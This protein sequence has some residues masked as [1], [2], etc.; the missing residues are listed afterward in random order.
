MSWQMDS[1]L[2]V[3]FA[4]ILIFVAS[5]VGVPVPPSTQKPFPEETLDFLV[6]GDTSREDVDAYF[7]KAPAGFRRMTFEADTVRTYAATAETWGVFWCA[8]SP[9][10][11]G[12]GYLFPRREVEHYLTLRFSGN[13]AL[14]HFAVSEFGCDREAGFCATYDGRETMALDVKGHLPVPSFATSRDEACAFYV[15]TDGPF[16]TTSV[17]SVII[18]DRPVGWLIDDPGYLEIATVSGQHRLEVQLNTGLSHR[19]ESVVARASLQ[20][21]PGGKHYIFVRQRWSASTGYPVGVELRSES[22]SKGQ[23]AIDER[24]RALLRD[25]DG[26]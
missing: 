24:W 14:A 11:P 4:C 8:L 3:R 21:D 16:W 7:S 12:C 18:D 9:Y 17:V 13:G 26:A 22:H 10:G 6:V 5:C 23:K 19:T 1:R 2:V 15:Y 25:A 20:C